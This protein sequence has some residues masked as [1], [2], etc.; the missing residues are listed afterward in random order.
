MKAIIIGGGIGGLTAAIALRRR[1]ID[2]DVYEQAPALAEVGA[3]ISLWA[4]ALKALAS[5]GL[6]NELKAISNESTAFS[7]RRWNGDLI[8]TIPGHKLKQRFG[9]AVTVVHRAELLDILLRTFPNNHLHLGKTCTGVEQQTD[10]V[11]AHFASGD[12]AVPS[13]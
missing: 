13:G 5:L 8:S 1:G 3:G 7:L 9:A 2:V 11:T 4:N 12:S 10:R 6:E